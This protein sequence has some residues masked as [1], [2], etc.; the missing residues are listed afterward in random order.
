MAILEDLIVWQLADEL[1]GEVVRL[2]SLETARRSFKLCDQLKDSSESVVGN[3]AEGYGRRQHNDFAR[4]L[5]IAMGSLRESEQWLR[6]GLA[7]R[8]WTKEEA[9]VALRLCIRLTAALSRFR[10]YLRNSPTP[11]L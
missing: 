11:N 7:R 3:I 1:C 6:R 4:F 8:A 2:T 9:E 5:D 10:R